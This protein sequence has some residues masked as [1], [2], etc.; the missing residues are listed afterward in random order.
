M[1]DNRDSLDAAGQNITARVAAGAA[2]L[3]LERP[4]WVQGVDLDRLKI[5]SCISCVLGQLYGDVSTGYDELD[6][7]DIEIDRFGFDQQ[8]WAADEYELLTAEWRRV[9]TSRRGQDPVEE[10]LIRLAVD[11]ITGD[12][13]ETPIDPVL[14]EAL[15][16][17]A[18]DE[19]LAA[20]LAAVLMRLADGIAAEAL[21]RLRF[22]LELEQAPVAHVTAWWQR[23]LGW[24]GF[25]SMALC[26]ERIVAR[27]A[28]SVYRECRECRRALD[29]ER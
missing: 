20:H 17:S 6:I 19:A 24:L 1:S 4:G 9:I 3:D 13:D 23:P 27:R 5:S 28:P 11:R 7:D 18:E 14:A 15:G 12:G 16:L 2:L 21:A 26:G 25:R 8:G 10:H 22:E 29:G